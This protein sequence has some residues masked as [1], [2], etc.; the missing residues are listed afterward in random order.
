MPPPPPKVFCLD[1]DIDIWLTYIHKFED[2]VTLTSEK[3]CFVLSDSVFQRPNKTCNAVN[4]L[5]RAKQKNNS[6]S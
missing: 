3:Y 5:W 4:V 2:P 6:D 1:N